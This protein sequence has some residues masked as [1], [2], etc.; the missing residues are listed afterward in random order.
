[1]TTPSCASQTVQFRSQVK[2]HH[3]LLVSFHNGKKAWE[4]A[5]SQVAGQWRV[6]LVTSWFGVISKIWMND[7]SCSQV[8]DYLTRLFFWITIIVLAPIN[9]SIFIRVAQWPRK[10]Q[11]VHFTAQINSLKGWENLFGQ[12]LGG[13]TTIFAFLLST[14][15]MFDA[16]ECDVELSLTWGTAMVDVVIFLSL[17]D[18]HKLTYSNYQLIF[19]RNC[20]QVSVLKF[21][22]SCSKQRPFEGLS[23]TLLQHLPDV[24]FGQY[25]SCVTPPSSRQCRCPLVIASNIILK[26]LI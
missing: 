22:V 17:S 24:H 11:V 7:R 21:C 23:I 8:N 15:I 2:L 5:D 25:I 9:M 16:T 20:F 13:L 6:V 3:R 10:Q 14:W 4:M 19:T 12:L 1:M 26:L 18:Q